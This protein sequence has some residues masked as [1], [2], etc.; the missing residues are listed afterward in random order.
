MNLK[1]IKEILEAE[2]LIG[3]DQLDLNV[4]TAFG[5]DLMS[6]VLA[7]VKSDTVLL[8]GLTNSQVIR[9]AEMSD[10]S[11]IIFVR[12]KNPSEE[13][14]ELGRTNKLVLMKT[15]DIMYVACGKLFE[16]GLK[17]VDIQGVER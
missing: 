14:I 7:F 3:E 4:E 13:V 2:I 12:G 8:T 9:T 10:V 11:V 16:N 6:D 15:K 17:G 1:K 5:A